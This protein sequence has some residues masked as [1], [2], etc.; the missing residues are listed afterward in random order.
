MSVNTFFFFSSFGQQN[1]LIGHKDSKRRNEDQINTIL[2]CYL[3]QGTYIGCF[4]D[5][6]RDRTLKGMVFYDFRKM[7]ST[8]CQDTCTERYLNKFS[9]KFWN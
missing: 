5:D 9:H 4:T 8:L 7:T 1:Y 6:A 3:Y 2:V